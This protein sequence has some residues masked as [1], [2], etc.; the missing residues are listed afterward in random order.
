MSAK[1]SEHHTD[2]AAWPACAPVLSILIPFYRDDPRPLLKALAAQALALGCEVEVVVL[3]DG[4]GLPE[5]A[6]GVAADVRA[7][8]TP[9]RLVRLDNNEGRAKGRNRLARNARGDY[10]LFI[11]SDMRPDTE[12]FLVRWLELVR[13]GE[14]AVACG[15]FKVDGSPSVQET[16]LHRSMA[17]RGECLPAKARN[18]FPAKY[19]FTNNLLVRRDVFSAEMFDEGF[20]GWGWE[21][22]EWGV[23]VG[24]RW[25]IVHIDNPAQNC[26][27]STVDALIRKYRQAAP[28]FARMRQTHPDVVSGFP[29]YQ[30]ARVLRP[31]P[32]RGRWLPALERLARASSAPLRVRELA[33]KTYRAGLYAEAL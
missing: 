12:N 33:L 30:A 28:N 24:R 3:D 26:G 25:P 2:N 7:M 4:S 9:A 27:L 14:V 23:R 29:T 22:V 13:E 32:L 31:L 1:P 6:E 17:T 19:V 16:A 18:R 15:G 11:D 8:K 5:L 21:D 20:V 10:F